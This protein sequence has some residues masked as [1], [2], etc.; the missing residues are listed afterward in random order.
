MPN[1]VVAG[2]G[3]SGLRVAAKLA[4]RGLRVT[5][6]ERLPVCGGQ[7]PERPLAR[8]LTAAALERG[9]DAR[10]GTCAVGW[11]GASLATL[12]VDGDDRIEADALVVATGCRPATRAELG[13][14]GDRCAGVLPAPAAV[15]LIESGVLVG[16]RPAV[17]GGSEQARRVAE[18]LLH[19]GAVSVVVVAPAEAEPMPLQTQVYSGWRA[20]E[21]RGT[22]RVESVTITRGGSRER[23]LAD[24]VILATGRIP[25]RNIEGAAFGGTNV[26]YC[27]PTEEPKTEEASDRAAATAAAE[28]ENAS[29]SQSAPETR[30]EYACRFSLPSALSRSGLPV[31]GSRGAP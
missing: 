21:V 17:I 4:E 26:V 27:Q 11:D 9:V 29:L 16:R 24:A 23:L 18:L 19:V 2:A 5:L 14:S 3:Q 7:E 25:A 31:S 12:G 20:E 1:A 15:H 6:V 30:K 28:V 8:D 10:L 13:I 22:A